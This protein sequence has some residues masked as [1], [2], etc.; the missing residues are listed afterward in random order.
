MATITKE[1]KIEASPDRVWDALSD[2]GVVHE[3]V[4]KGFVVSCELE[5]PETRVVTFLNGAIAREILVGADAASRRLAYSVVESPLGATHHNA[6]AQ[7]FADGEQGAR[8]VWITD[9]LPHEAGE[10]VD[11]MMEAGLGAMKQTLESAES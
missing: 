7:V 9:V 2:F 3:R 4:A 11:A 8:F 1:I 5:D 6:S 10:R